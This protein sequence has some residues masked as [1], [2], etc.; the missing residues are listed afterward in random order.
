M[1]CW[2]PKRTTPMQVNVVGAAGG[3]AVA[4][5]FGGAG[6]VAVVGGA[7]AGGVAGTGAAAPVKPVPPE[8]AQYAAAPATAAGVPAN[9]QVLSK[10]GVWR[11]ARVV[12]RQESL[13]AAT[14]AQVRPPIT[15]ERSRTPMIDDDASCFDR[16][17][18]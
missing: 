2:Q 18:C 14:P 4:G 8:L 6:G 15:T 13:N 9:V 11:G 7:A 17:H 3:V 10:S 1:F 12:Q 5:T 16:L